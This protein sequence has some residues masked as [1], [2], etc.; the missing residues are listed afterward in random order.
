[1]I[2][3]AIAVGII[4]WL[5]VRGGGESTKGKRSVAAL[6]EQGLMTL[7]RTL[8]GPVYWEGPQSGV[9]Y[10]V[11]QTPDARI[12][13]RYL[14]NGVP[15]GT[16]QQYPFVA[17]F[18]FGNALAAT[19]AVAN[20]A[21][22]VKIPVSGNG[23]AFYTRSSPTNVYLAFRGSNYQIEVFDPR[24]GRA[25]RLVA[26]G[27]IQPVF[28]NAPGA[29]TT[30]SVTAASVSRLTALPA[31]LGHPVYWIGAQPATTYELTQTPNGRVFV[32]YLP[33]GA[34]IGTSTH[35]LFVGTLPVSDAFGATSRAAGRPGAV[36]IPAGGGAVAFYSSSL[37]TNIY[38]AFPGAKYQI[39]IFDPNPQHGR[40][41]VSAGRI[42]QIP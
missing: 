13:V 16:N 22:S 39:E 6:S 26:R 30:S 1:V 29:T 34:K 14:P 3:I 27:Q 37:P 33:A 25:R 2:A 4:V 11:T 7:A 5:L 40:S 35:Y 31:Q 10:E 38:V 24:P 20:R 23:V 36:K 28:P 41:L 32:R 21:G 8:G 18:P 15:V 42:R 9:K 17:T 19:L 12:F